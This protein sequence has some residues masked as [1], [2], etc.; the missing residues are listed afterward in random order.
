MNKRTLPLSLELVTRCFWATLAVIG[1]TAIM[2]LIGRE[3]LGEA[4]IALL[5]LLPIGWSTARWGQVPGVCGSIA[6]ALAFDFFFIP[7]FNTFTVGSLEGWLVLIIFLLVSVVIVGRIQV[8]LTQ[9]QTRERE[10][11]FMYEM[12]LA[13]ARSQTPDEI[14]R[15]LAE[16]LQQL[17][18]AA[19]VQV[20]F[21]RE[22]PPHSLIA[23]SSVGKAFN[24]RPDRVVPI[25]AAR[26]LVGEICIWG[27]QAPLPPV[28]NRLLQN[29][30]AQGALTFERVR[31]TMGLYSKLPVNNQ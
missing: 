31:N 11:I 5:Y 25:M 14:A 23:R 22:D 29:F 10:A 1:V 30:A 6:A 20:S 28:E 18:Q 21:Q 12:S 4:V 8:G 19:L 26:G 15:T 16:Q 9:A 24:R 7:P 17:Y 27:E 13:L 3:A 2:R